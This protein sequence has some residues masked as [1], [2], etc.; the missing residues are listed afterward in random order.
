[1][2]HMRAPLV[3]I[4]VGC[5]LG[6]GGHGRSIVGDW[7]PPGDK[8]IEYIEFTSEG[9]LRIGQGPLLI[10]AGHYVL[11]GDT[12]SI[13]GGLLM[14]NLTEADRSLTID[15]PIRWVND[16]L[17]EIRDPESDKALG[18]DIKTLKRLTEQERLAKNT[19]NLDST[20][21]T[22][23][24]PFFSRPG[25]TLPDTTPVSQATT[26][27]SNVKNIGLA[28]N[29]YSTD[30]DNVLP[31]EGWQDAIK[32]YI[33]SE[34]YFKCPAASSDGYAINAD[35]MGLNLTQF[36][37]K[38]TVLIF[39]TDNLAPSVIQTPANMLKQSRHDGKRSIGYSDGS[40]KGIKNDEA[41]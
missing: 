33:K 6:C 2:A 25:L 21:A 3:L 4:L 23:V 11:H 17:F 7:A 40:V 39:E 5:L 30:Y 32:P 29:I 36:D 1:M 31:G 16:D 35:V 22:A 8:S 26:C 9:E 24:P 28:L 19:V 20:A 12:I 10:T 38:S 37:P 41:P 14:R 15:I 27:L 13:A 34:A 18:P